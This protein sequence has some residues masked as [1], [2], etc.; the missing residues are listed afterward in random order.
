MP[1]DQHPTAP[2][3]V[4]AHFHGAMER[5]VIRGWSASETPLHAHFGKDLL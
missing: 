5:E 3:T 4:S 2:V 1:G